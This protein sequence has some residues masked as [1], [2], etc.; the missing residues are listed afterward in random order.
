VSNDVIRAVRWDWKKREIDVSVYSKHDDRP[1]IYRLYANDPDF[2]GIVKLHGIIV[3]DE[4][5][6]HGE[7]TNM[8]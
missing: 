7:E 5:E 2:I 8:G 6:L 1:Y 3:P 4:E